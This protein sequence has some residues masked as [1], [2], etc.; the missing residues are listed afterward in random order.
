[1]GSSGQRRHDSRPT[2]GHQKDFPFLSIGGLSVQG[3]M[4]GLSRKWHCTSA[5]LEQH[6]PLSAA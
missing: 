4:L 5:S 1:M 3:L 2:K 6:A